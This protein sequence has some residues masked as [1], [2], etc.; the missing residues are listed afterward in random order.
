[1]K[2]EVSKA[3]GSKGSGRGASVLDRIRDCRVALSRWKKDNDANSKVRLTK[4]QFLFDE[5][6]LKRN[7]SPRVMQELKL[8]M[9]QA[10]RDEDSFWKQKCKDK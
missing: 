5:E 8:Q 7:P 2:Y 9:A 6:H 4:I 10:Y 1:M 3:W